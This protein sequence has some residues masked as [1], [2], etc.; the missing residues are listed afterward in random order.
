MTFSEIPGTNVTVSEDAAI[1]PMTCLKIEVFMRD[2][3][4][5]PHFKEKLL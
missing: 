3:V 2:F 1:K 5:K 4:R